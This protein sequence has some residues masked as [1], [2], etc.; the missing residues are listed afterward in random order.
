[1]RLERDLCVSNFTIAAM[2]ERSK[3]FC[4][5]CE[6]EC[7]FLSKY[8]R[9]IKSARHQQ[10]AA[11]LNIAAMHTAESVTS[12]TQEIRERSPILVFHQ[13]NNVSMILDCTVH[14]WC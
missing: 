5:V 1:M 8:E 14:V 11:T 7:H 3:F 2:A 9:H 13:S 4:A 6:I 10:L 12:P